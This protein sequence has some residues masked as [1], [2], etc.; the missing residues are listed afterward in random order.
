MRNAYI[1]AFAQVHDQFRIPEI[2]SVAE[3]FNFT[4]HFSQPVQEIDTSRPF[5]I[6]GLDDEEHA[7]IL[8]TR[9][10]LLKYVAVAVC[11]TT[12]PEM[13]RHICEFYATGTN[14]EE[15]H[16]ANRSQHERWS[17]YIPDTSFKFV[18]TGFNHTIPQKRQREAVESFSYMGFLGKI[19][20]KAPKITMCCYEE[21][22]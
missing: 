20:M 19:D 10:I 21:C 18:I 11:W 13:F 17:L 4:I 7:K 12:N 1:A 2:L 15:L 5:M 6:F 3:L 14:Y 8:A 9:C 16:G 22:E